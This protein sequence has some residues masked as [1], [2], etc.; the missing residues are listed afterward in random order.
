MQRSFF[1]VPSQKRMALSVFHDESGTDQAHDGF[2]LHGALFVPTERIPAIASSL[3][4]RRGDYP[5]RLH[6]ARLKDHPSDPKPPVVAAWL[7]AY[8]S[9]L[10][11]TCPYKCMVVDTASP[12]LDHAR[13]PRARDLYNHA[14]ALAIFGG[15]V[16]SFKTIDQVDLQVYS[17]HADR[18][19]DDPFVHLVPRDV[20]RRASNKRRFRGGSCPLVNVP[21]PSVVLVPGDRAHVPAELAPHW[22]LVQL[23]DLLTSAVRQAVLASSSLEVKLQFGA[24]LADYV[25]DAQLPP[26]LQR[27][28]IYRRFSVS[29]FPD[30]KGEY[31]DVELA[32]ARVNQPRLFR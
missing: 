9:E 6:F 32:V 19:Q 4:S 3:S 30:A 12:G 18:A 25:S 24:L 14:A 23:T 22:E 1:G 7:A 28:D 15:V 20:A 11:D 8:F 16:W 2:Q 17:E 29:C 27:K 21:V 5:E 13:Y 10:T 31:Y 26:W